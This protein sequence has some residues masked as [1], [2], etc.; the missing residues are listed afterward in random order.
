MTSE[1][2]A[3]CYL[4][5]LTSIIFSLVGAFWETGD[6][7]SFVKGIVHPDLNFTHPFATTL[8]ME[9]VVTFC[10]PHNVSRV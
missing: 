10:D 1:K 5:I 7:L 9:A 8:S 4:I 6:S 2:S 3:K